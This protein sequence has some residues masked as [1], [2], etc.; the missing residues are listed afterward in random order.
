M[1]KLIPALLMFIIH[2]PPRHMLWL[3]GHGELKRVHL[4][5][6]RFLHHLPSIL[7][8]ITAQFRTALVLTICFPIMSVPPTPQFDVQALLATN[9]RHLGT[10]TAK[11]K[12]ID[13]VVCVP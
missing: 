4:S 5:P 9:P 11:A 8:I 3:G 7:Q 6:F 10:P 2:Q 12:I 13:L 1:A